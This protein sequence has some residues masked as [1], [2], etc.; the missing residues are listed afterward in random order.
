MSQTLSIQDNYLAVLVCLG[1][2]YGIFPS[3]YPEIC[4]DGKKKIKKAMV[5]WNLCQAH[6]LEVGMTKIPGD[7]ESLSIVRHVGLHVYFSFMKSSLYI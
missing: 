7:H 3:I 1:I 2:Y 5:S 4:L 6:L